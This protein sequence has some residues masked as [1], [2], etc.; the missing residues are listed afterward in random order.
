MQMGSIYSVA[1]VISD[2]RKIDITGALTIPA[3]APPMAI[4]AHK[5]AG[6]SMPNQC[7]TNSA[8]R[9]PA[10]APANNVGANE[11]A[12]PPALLLQTVAKAFNTS[13]KVSTAM[14]RVVSDALT[15]RGPPARI[16]W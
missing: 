12:T 13:S 14:K 9:V 10:T 2:I 8:N 11:P 4:M 15:S 5:G 3:N 6:R 16:S 1:P 7:L